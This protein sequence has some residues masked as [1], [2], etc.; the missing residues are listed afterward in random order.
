MS[1]EPKKE[2]LVKVFEAPTI[3][4]ATVVRSLLRSAGIL[5]PDFESAEPFALHD[6]PEGWHDAEVWVPESQAGDARKVIAD[7]Q[8]GGAS[9]SS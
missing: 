7:A 6:P 3:T 4:E 9:S 2:K 1:P 5:S 8:K